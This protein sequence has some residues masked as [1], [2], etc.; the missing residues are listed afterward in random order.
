MRTECRGKSGNSSTTSEV[1]AIIPVS[2]SASD[3][4]SAVREMRITPVLDI[5]GR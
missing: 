5:I 1:F 4:V 3:W 2:D